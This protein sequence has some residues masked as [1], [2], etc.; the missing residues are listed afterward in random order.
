M[1]TNHPSRDAQ[2][3][4]RWTETER[5]TKGFKSTLPWERGASVWAAP[6]GHM[7]QGAHSLHSKLRAAA[8]PLG[9]GQAEVTA[10]P[11]PQSLSFTCQLSTQT[12]INY[13]GHLNNL[14]LEP[15]T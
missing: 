10:V 3:A 4:A 13:K 15:A 1:C 7:G 11:A 2:G 5:R 14:Q 9:K 6:S 8:S 12:P